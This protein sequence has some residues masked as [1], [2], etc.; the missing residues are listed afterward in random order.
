LSI[1]ITKDNFETEVLKSDI[2]VL[3]DFFAEWCGPC[4][5]LAPI[6]EQLAEEHSE[7][8]KVV[9]IDVDND[10]ELA[11]QF[12]VMSVPTMLFF[13]DGELKGKHIGVIPKEA[14][15]LKLKEYFN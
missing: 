2:P 3:V 10:A 4:K 9:K 12:G 1:T 15:A 11:A 6:L 7:K 14:I 5:M 8:L 13:K